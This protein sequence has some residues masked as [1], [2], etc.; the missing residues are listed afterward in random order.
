MGPVSSVLLGAQRKGL[1]V[2]HGRMGD[3]CIIMILIIAFIFQKDRSFFRDA[4][5]DAEVRRALA[6]L[7][8]PSHA[9][10]TGLSHM[11]LWEDQGVVLKVI[12]EFLEACETGLSR[13]E[14]RIRILR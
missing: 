12:R 3:N 1:D 2:V 10:L 14:S 11:L 9:R 5:G 6:L 8:R 13:W 4:M 7:A